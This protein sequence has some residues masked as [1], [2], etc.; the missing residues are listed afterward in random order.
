MQ[1]GS[2]VISIFLLFGSLSSGERAYKRLDR[3]YNADKEKCEVLAKKMIAKD[4]SKPEPYFF[5][6]RVNFDHYRE[7]TSLRKKSSYLSRSLS[8]AGRLQKLK[9]ARK[10]Y[11]K[12]EWDTLRLKIEE[13]L[14]DFIRELQD[15]KLGAKAESLM[16]KAQKIN[17]YTVVY[18]VVEDDDAAVMPGYRNG[19]YFG[20]PSGKENVA[21]SGVEKEKEVIRLL[22]I[23]RRNRGMV[24]L[25]WDEDLARAA[26]YHSYDM[27]T[28]KYFDHQSYDSIGGKLVEVGNTFVRIRRFYTKGFV[29]SENL[30]AGSSTAKGTY[31]Q[32]YN[33]P[34]HYRN[35]FN[36]SS[37]K[38]GVG[39][40]Y[41]A[42]SPYG[43]YWS[44]CTARD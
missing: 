40:Y 26:R 6:S 23:E 15:A 16:T 41:D 19:Q 33:S 27:A 35:M 1:I 24:K 25:V 14:P 2:I 28:Q 43:Y 30:A 17:A 38:V 18:E 7:A 32:W 3:K 20:L 39:L 13:E 31:T 10:M 34:G 37:K 8:Y 44:F 4:R 11:G 12:R 42:A 36:E 9:T 5:V 29:N 22:N 21:S